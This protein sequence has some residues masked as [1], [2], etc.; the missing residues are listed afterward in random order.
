[1]CSLLFLQLGI[2][3]T[4]SQE[5]EPLGTGKSISLKTPGE[6]NQ[7]KYKKANATKILTIFLSLTWTPKLN[8]FIEL[9]FL[10]GPLALARDHLTV[11]DE[12]FFVLNSDVVCDFP[13]KEMAAFHRNHGKEGTIVVSLVVKLLAMNTDTAF[14]V[15]HK[16]RCGYA[17]IVWHHLTLMLWKLV[18]KFFF[19]VAFS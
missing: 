2:T 10:A 13:F 19:F 11:D 7:G 8:N 5:K 3:I 4:I 16:S 15:L 18:V 9:L 6:E 12:P 17:N 14:A 1:M